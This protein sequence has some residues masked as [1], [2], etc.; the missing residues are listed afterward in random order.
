MSWFI[1]KKKKRFMTSH[2]LRW[3]FP[4]LLSTSGTRIITDEIIFHNTERIWW[5]W[6]VY[7]KQEAFQY[8]PI[9][10]QYR[11]IHIAHT[12]TL[13]KT[14]REEIGQSKILALAW[15]QTFLTRVN[16]PPLVTWPDLTRQLF[17]SKCAQWMFR[18][19][20]RVWVFSLAAFG[21][22]TRK[23]WRGGGLKAPRP[24]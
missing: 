13:T 3:P 18:R 2:G 5:F 12:G 10:L 1:D 7:T 11:D 24:E 8:S 19:S 21:N 22:D 6:L 9:G 16:E 14:W 4:V 20:H 17:L 23:T 15:L